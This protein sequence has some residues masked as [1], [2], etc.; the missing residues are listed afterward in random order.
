MA[1]CNLVI[2]NIHNFVD[3]TIYYIRSFNV[4]QNSIR[5]W[6]LMI[7]WR[8]WIRI[9]KLAFGKSYRAKEYKKCDN[10]KLKYGGMN[11]LNFLHWDPT[12][13]N[14]LIKSETTL[15]ILLSHYY[16]SPNSDYWWIHKFSFLHTINHRKAI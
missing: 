4:W 8:I 10:D 14:T 5:N 3:N 12:H 6:S 13:P 1:K 9:Q 7:N 16:C 2:L 11:D 15:Q